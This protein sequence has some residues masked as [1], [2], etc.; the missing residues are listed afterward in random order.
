MAARSY[1]SA[2][3]ALARFASQLYGLQ[4]AAQQALSQA[5]TAHAQ[6]AAANAAAE[7]ANGQV[8]AASAEE[9]SFSREIADLMQAIDMREVQLGAQAAADP[10]LQQWQL[11]VPE[12]EAARSEAEARGQTAQEE[13][14][15]AQQDAQDAQT[16]LDSARR[17]IADISSQFSGAVRQAVGLLEEAVLQ[18]IQNVSFLKREWNR[19][20]KDVDHMWKEAS[21]DENRL[22][23][24]EYLIGTGHF[25]GLRDM[26]DWAGHDVVA[27]AP[28]IHALASAWATAANDM[29]TIVDDLGPLLPVVCVIVGAVVGAVVGF[30]AG[31]V[32]AIP[33]AIAGAEE[34]EEVAEYIPAVVDADAAAAN[35][36][37]RASDEL[38]QM[39]GKGAEVDMTQD[40]KVLEGSLINLGMDGATADIPDVN[41]VLS[42]ATAGESVSVFQ[43]TVAVGTDKAEAWIGS[44]IKSATGAAQ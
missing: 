44:E 40:T 24:D 17:W 38:M 37:V 35:S 28:E 29:V 15:S 16:Q 20:V 3:S 6:Q 11:Q 33:G 41:D 22:L 1:G 18:G 30:A 43:A 9:A 25:S 42:Q 13:L 8:E 27:A 36:A 4:A 7:E 10:T 34:G 31:G 21:R 39:D 5:Q 19:A 32:G 23:R 12:L 14:A 26:A 2:S